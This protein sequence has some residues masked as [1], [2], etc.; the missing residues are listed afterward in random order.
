ML[1]VLRARA[2]SMPHGNAA[3]KPCSDDPTRETL[4]GALGERRELLSQRR[5]PRTDG[6]R[7]P[8]YFFEA[9]T[10][11]I[12]EHL[13]KKAQLF[14]RQVIAALPLIDG[15]EQLGDL[16]GE[17]LVRMDCMATPAGKHG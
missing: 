3:R 7:R 4:V 11:M 15:G 5:Q 2:R 12:V 1:P 8:S 17:G 6:S 13:G 10:H 14:G 9:L 16:C